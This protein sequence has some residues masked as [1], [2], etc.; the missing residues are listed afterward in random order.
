MAEELTDLQLYT[1]IEQVAGFVREVNMDPGG[2]ALCL[3]AGDGEPE[4][5]G[6][7]TKRGLTLEFDRGFPSSIITPFGRYAIGRFLTSSML[8]NGVPDPLLYSALPAF[9]QL[10]R[11]PNLGGDGMIPIVAV[12]DI[13]FDPEEPHEPE[14][15]SEE[16]I[17]RRWLQA[18]DTYHSLRGQQR[19][20]SIREMSERDEA[21]FTERDRTIPAAPELD[22]HNAER[23][24]R[25]L[26]GHGV[27]F[28]DQTPTV[29]HWQYGV[30]V[31]LSDPERL[32]NTL[33]IAVEV[34]PSSGEQRLALVNLSK[35]AVRPVDGS[36]VKGIRFSF[37]AQPAQLR[38][39][40]ARGRPSASAFSTPG[41]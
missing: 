36:H 25:D 14:R 39:T 19:S 20:P 29:Q 41:L 34:S 33:A 3:P 22:I 18:A 21:F 1:L 30:V 9:V 7:S 6:P 2:A 16:T 35:G 32:P 31:S 40:P 23:V 15:T 4:Y 26:K 28:H 27:L 8:G 38:Q 5:G 10:A 11:R 17:R 24:I 12:G 37:D 13:T